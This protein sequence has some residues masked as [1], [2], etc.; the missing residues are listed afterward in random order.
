MNVRIVDMKMEHT[1]TNPP[2]VCLGNYPIGFITPLCPDGF[3]EVVGQTVTVVRG[4]KEMVT[5]K[6][7]SGKK[8]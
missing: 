8:G 2:V 1:I 7:E 6:I 3:M 5:V 4:Q